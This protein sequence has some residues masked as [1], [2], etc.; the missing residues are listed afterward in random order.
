[1]QTGLQGILATR[2]S[3]PCGKAQHQL[4]CSRR[5]RSEAHNEVLQR[6]TAGRLHHPHSHL[7]G[8]FLERSTSHQG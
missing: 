5:T 2:G 4:A 3:T 7:H 8:Q 1:M 6:L